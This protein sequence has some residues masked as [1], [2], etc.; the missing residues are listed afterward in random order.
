MQLVLKNGVL[1]FE[2]ALENY[3]CPLGVVCVGKYSAFVVFCFYDEN[4]EAG[5]QNVINLCR[6][7][8]ERKRQVIHQW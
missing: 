4:A 7:F 8:F 1:K 3:L 2:F 6:S 5:H